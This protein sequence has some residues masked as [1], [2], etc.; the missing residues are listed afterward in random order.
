MTRPDGKAPSVTEID[1]DKGNHLRRALQRGGRTDD[2]LV[3][4][5]P[6]RRAAEE[7]GS[8]KAHALGCP[9]TSVHSAGTLED[10]CAGA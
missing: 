1:V 4:V 2:Q 8:G 7:P 6:V 3:R 9:L 10:N 5:A